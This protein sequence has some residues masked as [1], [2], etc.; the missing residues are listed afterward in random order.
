MSDCLLSTVKLSLDQEPGSFVQ[1][2]ALIVISQSGLRMHNLAKRLSERVLER[3]R[4]LVVAHIDADG[5]SAGS[6]ACSSLIHAGIEHDILFIKSLDEEASRNIQD[7]NPE[8]VWFTDIG[9]GSYDLISDLPGIITDHHVPSESCMGSK[10]GRLSSRAG[11]SK[12][13]MLNPDM[14]GLEGSTDISGAGVTYLVAKEIGQET[15]YLSSLA[16][17][18]AVGD[19]QDQN[20]RRLVG[21]NREILRDAISGG[22]VKNDV[23]IRFFG[24]ETRPVA[25]LLTYSSDPLLPGL[26]GDLDSCTKF[27]ERV[28]VPVMDEDRWRCWSDVESTEKRVILSALT[29]LLLEAGF[30]HRHIE[31]MVGE[32]YALIQEKRGSVLRDAKEFA[33]LLNSCGR[34]DRAEVGLKI[35]LG[36]REK[37]LQEALALLQTHRGYLVESLEMAE[38]IGIT[39]LDHLQYFHGRKRIRDTVI[40]ITAGM[41]M[42]SPEISKSLPL[43]AFAYSDDGVK[44][45]ARGTR[46]LV[47]GGLDLSVVMKEAAQS[48]GGVGGGHNI[49]AGATIP[50]N[51]EEE[52]LELAER[53]IESQIVQGKASSG[54]SRSH[55]AN[56]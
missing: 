55:Q 54:S 15:S 34:Y 36:D 17:V 30:S 28:E 56:H 18:G 31:R 35:C 38:E 46:G 21:S 22:W 4:I 40:G 13:S 6:I 20:H 41:L 24:R 32:C 25:K 49:A 7:R 44:V 23:D 27:L 5:I 12:I 29:I 37:S 48:L 19:M 9:A 47:S 1:E 33:T 2:I 52:F 51:C 43:F 42:S 16:V 14:Y 45:S 11:A 53:I 39:E 50:H 8:F 3:K 10:E 26:S